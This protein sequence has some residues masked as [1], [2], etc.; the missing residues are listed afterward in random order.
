[1]DVW[2]GSGVPPAPED[3]ARLLWYEIVLPN[4]DALD[5]TLGRVRD[6]GV[7]VEAH[8]SGWLVRDPS[9]NGVVLRI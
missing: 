1:M 4:Q 5:A 3:R 7:A 9:R 2:A 6:A 8:G